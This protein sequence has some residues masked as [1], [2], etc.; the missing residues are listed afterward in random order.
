MK[1]GLVLNGGGSRGAYE[2]GAWQALDALGVRFDG[3][4]GTSIGALNAAL[5]AQGDLPGAVAIWSNITIRQIMVVEDDDDFAIEHMLASK[6]DVIPFLRE[7]MRHMRMDISPLEAL[8]RDSLDEARIRARGMRL[9][10]M[11]TRAPQ[12]TGAPMLLEDMK[13]GSLVDWVIASASCFPIF[14]A[15]TIGGQRYIDGGYY[16]NLPI[17]MALADGMDE[18]VAVELHPE[19]THPE[20]ARMPWLKTVRPLHSLGGFLDFN[21]D[22]LRRSRLMG[23]QDALK[24][25]GRLDGFRYAFRRLDALA[26]SDGAHRFMEALLRFDGELIRRGLIYRGQ[27][28]NAPL[29]AVLQRETGQRALGWKDVWVRGLELCAEALGQREDAIYDADALIRRTR[30]FCEA[31]RFSGHFDEAG[32][33]AARRRGSR[34]L[35]AFVYQRL[36]AGEGLPPE[37]LKRLGETPVEVA[38]AMFLKECCFPV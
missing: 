28:A 2:I 26:V 13:P 29:L 18:V 37:L 15:R 23:Y 11:A 17:D 24:L 20:Y 16:D 35:L 30:A 33:Q 6:R 5:F 4:Y 10:V 27:P 1:R 8:A 25:W 38:G 21:P 7:N 19:Y 34:T 3:V 32:L 14:P 31:Q 22:L 12:L 9:G 36:A